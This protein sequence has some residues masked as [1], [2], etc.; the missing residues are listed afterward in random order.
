MA[1]RKPPSHRP[2]RQMDEAAKAIARSRE[3]AK[4]DKANDARGPV[5]AKP[6]LARLDKGVASRKVAAPPAFPSTKRPKKG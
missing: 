2:E 4:G 5:D 6:T 3:L 1:K